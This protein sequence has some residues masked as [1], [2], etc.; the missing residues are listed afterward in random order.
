MSASTSSLERHNK[1]KIKLNYITLEI[2]FDQKKNIIEILN[3]MKRKK[4]TDESKN[5]Q[6]P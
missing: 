1:F 6:L 5:F 4:F 3:M 2:M